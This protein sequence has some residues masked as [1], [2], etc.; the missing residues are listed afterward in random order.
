MHKWKKGAMN[1][2]SAQS[3]ELGLT[4]GC[5]KRLSF[6]SSP[7]WAQCA[8][9][10]PLHG[11]REPS[12]SHL[13]LL[14]VFFLNYPSQSLSLTLLLSLVLPHLALTLA[15][16]LSVFLFLL[17]SACWFPPLIFSADPPLHLPT[18]SNTWDICWDGDI[19][20]DS[21]GFSSCGLVTPCPTK[22]P[23]GGWGGQ[24]LVCALRPPMAPDPMAFLA[25][26]SRYPPPPRPPTALG[27][28]SGHRSFKDGLG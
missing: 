24:I 4:G 21:W 10:R 2:T 19:N 27:P 9:L 7:P 22:N 13:L 1:R 5:A 12:K 3:I 26:I 17:F 20:A 18:R 15:L 28:L 25:P 6:F 8:H 16:Y 23:F 14:H 11:R